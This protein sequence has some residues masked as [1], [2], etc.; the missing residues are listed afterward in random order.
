MASDPYLVTREGLDKIKARLEQIKKIDRPQN[1][2]D[3]EVARAHGDLRE[4]AEY[5]AAKERQGFLDGEMRSLEDKI[6]RAQVVD[7]ASLSGTKVVFGAK[8]TVLNVD[9][10]E[11]SQFQIVGE[12]EADAKGGRISYKAPIA[13]ALLGK[14]LGDEVVFN[15]P[16]GARTY[17]ITAIDFQ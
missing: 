15:A 2:R 12:D 13:K 1:V 10:D 16:G 17:E 14:K 9:N 4:N 8:V 7:I 3:I 6:A 5:H 11:T